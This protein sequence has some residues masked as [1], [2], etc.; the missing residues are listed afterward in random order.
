MQQAKANPW[1][2]DPDVSPW[3]HDPDAS[4]DTAQRKPAAPPAKRK[5]SA[6]DDYTHAV[7]DAFGDLGK[8]FSEPY[9][10]TVNFLKH[11]SFES[12][13]NAVKTNVGATI[14][15]PFAA[16][17]AL[18]SPVLSGP[19]A[20]AGGKLT[21]AGV[22]PNAGGWFDDPVFVN[23]QRPDG[24]ADA[25][26]L[27]A[28]KAKKPMWYPQGHPEQMRPLVLNAQGRPDLDQ[29]NIPLD[30]DR[31]KAANTAAV[32]GVANMV[33]AAL[34]EKNLGLPRIGASRDLV[35]VA[36][37]GS[38]DLPV[39]TGKVLPPRKT[40]G[41]PK[42]PKA[43]ARAL[44]M[45][46]GDLNAVGPAVQ[47]RVQANPDLTFAEAIGPKGI[48]R[49]NALS[50]VDQGVTRN[51]TDQMTARLAQTPHRINRSFEAVTGI[52][53]EEAQEGIDRLVA[54]GQAEAKPLYEQA[55]QGMADSP[56]I[57]HLVQNVPAIRKGL[58]PAA[59]HLL[60]RRIDPYDL[61]EAFV[62]PNDYAVTAGS[63]QIRD[64]LADVRELR[65][66]G[67]KRA[68]QEVGPSLIEHLAEQGG[69]MDATGDLQG[70]DAQRV[71]LNKGKV[72]SLRKLV[73][74]TG[75]SMDDAAVKAW[76]A[77]YF[78]DV[79]DQ[80]TLLDAMRNE[81]AGKPMQS[82]RNTGDLSRKRYL[83]GLE[84]RISR[85][86][87][88]GDAQPEHVARALAN[89]DAYVQ[90]LQDLAEGMQGGSMSPDMEVEQVP[91]L[92]QLDMVKRHI[93]GRIKYALANG[94][95]ETV[96][97][98]TTANSA[99]TDELK[100]LSEPYRQALD[101]A[102][103]YLSAQEAFQQAPRR[104]MAPGGTTYDYDNYVRGLSP[105]NRNAHVAGVASDLNRRMFSREGGPASLDF[106]A[107]PKA[108]TRFM[109]AL[110]P[111]AGARLHDQILSTR[112]MR[113]AS[114][115]MLRGAQRGR[116][117][118]EQRQILEQLGIH[119]LDAFPTNKRDL[120]RM[121][122]NFV[123]GLVQDTV[124]RAQLG[125]N[126]DAIREYARLQL[127]NANLTMREI[128]Q[129]PPSRVRTW[130]EHVLKAGKAAAMPPRK[131]PPTN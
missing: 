82:M 105:Q 63:K 114:R 80:K 118:E 56:E 106:M 95:A 73:R 67:V 91:S 129:L 100:R 24:P 113:D 40:A 57:R 36:S 20:V 37:R 41:P 85:L 124:H 97:S 16:I 88:P 83:E 104:F 103:D 25:R 17:N 116:V 50:R 119:D 1:D 34:P 54:R 101:V 117:G 127:Q 128:E 70:M 2:A 84:Q 94:D 87:V 13:G 126:G 111:E 21:D 123:V 125:W 93:D 107:S 10:A 49:V 33:L 60:N 32:N 4:V 12:Y 14:Q 108:R 61:S 71:V 15:R 78:R 5:S 75:M 99:L 43:K 77:G 26:T 46:Q 8:T 66:G 53:P 120:L 90:H 59:E 27:A 92:Q 23:Y 72:G 110:G 86:N 51:V 69:V 65:N 121:T 7:G 52:A 18:A 30:Y 79:P 64:Y 29:F 74:P 6:L 68:S 48:D 31:S 28:L 122:S 3:D 98:L 115:Q 76:E 131:A 109:S 35:P 44:Q 38:E 58:G 130:M 39:V 45:A 62:V 42:L 11:P 96:R 22:R 89:E 81:L 9:N 102:G 19:A 112:E 47:A 55:F